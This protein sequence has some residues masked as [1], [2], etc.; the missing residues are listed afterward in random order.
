MAA[1]K[2]GSADIGTRDDSDLAGP[3][4]PPTIDP[5]G[6]GPASGGQQL[7]RVTVNLTNRS[8]G[9]LQKITEETGLSKTDVINRAVQIYA[10]VEELL[11]E[12]N[13]RLTVVNPQGQ[14]EKIYIL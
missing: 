1:H 11:T 10:L 6:H 14:L 9:D 5:P 12:G 13:G 3:A 7:V 8:Y 2:S 4:V